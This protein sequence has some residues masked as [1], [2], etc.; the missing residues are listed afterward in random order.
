MAAGQAGAALHTVLQAYQANLLTLRDLDQGLYKG[1]YVE[2]SAPPE[3]RQCSAGPGEPLFWTEL[4]SS[5]RV[6]IC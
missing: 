6:S 3:L 1:H 2:Y 5:I 4:L